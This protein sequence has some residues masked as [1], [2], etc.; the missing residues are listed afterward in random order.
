MDIGKGIVFL[1]SDDAGYMNGAGH[2]VDGRV[3]AT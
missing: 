1:A 2:I 3:T